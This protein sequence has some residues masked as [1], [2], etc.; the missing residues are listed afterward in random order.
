[1]ADAYE[2]IAWKLK[3]RD[4]DEDLG[5]RSVEMVEEKEERRG[6]IYTSPASPWLNFWKRPGSQRLRDAH[7]GAWSWEILFVLE[8]R[9][10]IFGYRLFG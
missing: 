4:G 9:S 6:F 8:P 7:T 10:T 5:C 2:L 1:M 3:M